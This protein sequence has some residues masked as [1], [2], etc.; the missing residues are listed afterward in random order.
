MSIELSYDFTAAPTPSAPTVVLIGSLGSDRSMWDP[1][2]GA[3]A[4]VA[5]VIAVDLRGHG[6]SPVPPGPYSVGDL[7]A[8]VLAVLDVRSIDSAHVVGLSIGG[9]LCIDRCA[10]AASR[11]CV[12]RHA[13]ANRRRGETVPKLPARMVPNLWPTP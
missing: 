7:A 12:P 4:A 9:S 10:C 8:D 1:Q 6:D 11:C 2:I 5:D 3:L 13:S